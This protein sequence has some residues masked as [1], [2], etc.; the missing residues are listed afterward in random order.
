MNDVPPEKLKLFSLASQ[1]EI[2][3]ENKEFILKIMK[4]D[5]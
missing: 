1:R 3:K 4:L 2:L 5:P